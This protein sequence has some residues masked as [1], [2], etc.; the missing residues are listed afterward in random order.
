MGVNAV[1]LEVDHG[2]D[3]ALE[4]Y[5][6]VGYREHDRFLMTKWLNRDSK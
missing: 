3:S 2:N 6:R 1:H 4:L 5:R